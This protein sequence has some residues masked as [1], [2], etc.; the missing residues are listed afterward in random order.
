MLMRSSQRGD[1]L[2]EV[3]L[4]IVILSAATLAGFSVMNKGVAISYGVLERT[5]TRSRVSQQLELLT[6]IRDQYAQSIAGGSG[7]ANYP[8]TLWTD[9]RNNRASDPTSANSTAPSTC[10]PSA[11]ARPFFIEQNP[12][13]TYKLTNYTPSTP[14]TTPTPGTGMWI[15]AVPSPG[16]TAVG[17]IDFYIK[18]CWDSVAGGSNETISSTVR[19]YDR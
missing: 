4:A 1:T 7:A 3:M 10:T 6:Y 8:A 18:S 16:A 14:A 9:I 12:D 15:E 17:Y 13:T 19:L 5:E 2:I 11:L